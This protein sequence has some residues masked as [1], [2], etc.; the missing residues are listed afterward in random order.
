MKIKN[1]I[2]GEETLQ[3]SRLLQ[4][5]I[6]QLDRSFLLHNMLSVMTMVMSLRMKNL[7]IYTEITG[8]LLLFTHML[9]MQVHPAATITG[10]W[11]GAAHPAP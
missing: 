4:Q 1:V 9:E 2:F 7:L 6:K 10:V 3:G 11:C 5:P 8:L